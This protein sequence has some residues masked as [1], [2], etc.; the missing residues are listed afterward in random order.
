MAAAGL[1]PNP[2]RRMT[3]EDGPALGARDMWTCA[4]AWVW[5]QTAVVAVAVAA[6]G[7]RLGDA[8]RHLLQLKLSAR[9]NPPPSVGRALELAAHNVSV[10]A[11][12]LLLGVAGAHRHHLT[13]TL[14]DWALLASIA[15]NTLLVGAAVGAYGLRLAPY[16]PQ[17]PVEWAA[18]ALGAASWLAHRHTPPSIPDGLLRL[19]VIAVLLLISAALETWAVPHR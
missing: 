10:A 4:Y 9:T 2:V 3:P 19:A 17:L 13:R 6:G 12:P 11:W 1:T 15:L 14:G 8:T 7:S 5:F 16:V 18:V